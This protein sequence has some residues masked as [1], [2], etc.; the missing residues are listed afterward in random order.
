LNNKDNVDAILLDFS[1]AF[2]KVP[3]QR[4]LKKME[5]YGVNL[6]VLNWVS[7]FLSDRKQ[8]VLVDGVKSEEASVTSGVPQGTVLGPVLFLIYINDM[9]EG[10]SSQTRLFAD[11]SLLYR[12]VRSHLDHIILQKDIDKLQIWEEKWQM[13]FNP[14]KCEVLHISTQKKK[15]N[16]QYSIHNQPLQSV[17]KAKYL[18]MTI[19]NDLKLNAHIEKITKK[20]NSTLGLLKRN[21]STCPINVKKQ[22]YTALVRPTIEYAATVWDPHR[23]LHAKSSTNIDKI[24][25]IQ[26]RAAR[27]I[28]SDYKQ[29]SSPSVMIRKLDLTPLEERRKQLKLTMLYKIINKEIAI[30]SSHLVKRSEGSET[31]GHHQKLHI[32]HSRIDRH[33]HSF[34]PDTIRLWNNL[35]NENVNINNSTSFRKSLQRLHLL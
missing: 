7:D 29:T 9:P 2:D 4:L 13:E 32:P 10:V 12:R 28:Y 25:K 20:A 1:K 21:I 30:P 24:E 34:F 22:A 16:H 5:Y 35:P 27:F 15:L 23:Q 31:K 19:S 14:S 6:N 17:D 33:L 18:G 3:H 26:R 8:Q 11:D